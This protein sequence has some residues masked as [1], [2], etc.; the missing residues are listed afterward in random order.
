MMQWRK[1]SSSRMASAAAAATFRQVCA[2]HSPER[3]AIT[4]VEGSGAAQRAQRSASRVE[5]NFV[6]GR[7]AL[8]AADV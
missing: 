2:K 1:G 3:R 8:Q 5:F 7:R 6:A 4:R